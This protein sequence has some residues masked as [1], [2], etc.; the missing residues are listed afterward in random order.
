M[1]TKIVFGAAVLLAGSLMAADSSPKDDIIAAAKKLGNESNYTWR[2]TVVVPEDAQFKP[3]PTDGKT[4]KGGFT[5]VKMSFFNNPVQI[6][7]KGKKS[8]FTD[9]EG[10]WQTAS[11]AEGEEGP[12][13]FMAMFVRNL[14]TPVDEVTELAGFAKDLKKDGDA[15]V[16]DLS[17]EG[18]KAKL[19]FKGSGGTATNP[20]GSVKFWLKDGVLTKYEFK[21]TGTVKWNDN[22]FPNDR[23]TTVEIKDVG[24]TK[25]EVPDEAK[26]KVS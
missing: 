19:V 3:E 18:A 26:K 16:A 22:E 4:E 24:K 10:A 17:E 12:G 11:N 2:T 5:Y 7:V 13:Q 1:R 21:V 8:A 25:L 23:T 15:Y 14:Q 6:V 9:Q 20:K